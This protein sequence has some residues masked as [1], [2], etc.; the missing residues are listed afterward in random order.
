MVEAAVHDD[1]GLNSSQIRE[2]L[3][4]SYLN[5]QGMHVESSDRETATNSDSSLCFGE[6]L[7]D[8]VT[9]MMDENHLRAQAATILYDLGMGLGKLAMQ[10]FLEFPNL[11]KV[12]GVELAH[13]R[14]E[15]AKSALAQ[16][17]KM[18]PRSGVTWNLK[19]LEDGTCQL[20]ETPVTKLAPSED[21]SKISRNPKM[22]F[23]ER[24]LEFKESNLFTVTECKEADIVICE[25][26]I[27]QTKFGQLCLLL[28]SLRKGVRILTY[29]DLVE[30][31]A[32]AKLESPFRR[33]VN[34]TQDDVFPASWC[35]QG[36]H[37]HLFEK[38]E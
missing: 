30:I 19:Q 14:A 11:K 31:Y 23:E 4:K 28:N 3:Q 32:V 17:A 35:V 7:P 16:L 1:I 10:A 6:V 18:Q 38:V 20:T 2:I 5:L 37:F 15:K 13:T 21:D 12:I 9:K 33:L 25:T 26:K 29:E 36:T 22:S 34:N 24:I 8:G 27:R